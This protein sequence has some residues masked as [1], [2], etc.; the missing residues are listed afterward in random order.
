MISRFDVPNKYD[1]IGLLNIRVESTSDD[2]SPRDHEDIDYSLLG[3]LSIYTAYRFQIDTDT[4]LVIVA[5]I[6]RDFQN[7]KATP[8]AISVGGFRGKKIV[9]KKRVY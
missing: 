8:N 3:C 6:L 1:A 2:N 7:R 4:A 9:K 5:K